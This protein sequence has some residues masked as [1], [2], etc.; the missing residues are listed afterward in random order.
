MEAV[1]KEAIA[2]TEQNG[3]IFLDEIDKIAGRERSLGP[4]VSREG[5]QRDLLPIVEGSTVTTKYGPVK[6]DHILFIA[7]GAFHVAKPSDLIPELQGRF[8]IRVELSPLTKEDFIRILT[9][10]QNALIKQYTA[11]LETEGITLDFTRDALEEIAA[12]AVLVNERSENIGARRLFTI[13]ER[14]LEE[15][16]F[17]A[18]TLAEKK[19]RIDAEAVKNRLK[20]IIKDED[21]SRFIL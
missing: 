7:A 15:I 13:M 19:I 6:T 1:V 4:D 9:E 11:L 20:D 5:V 18:P 16:S 14:L 8:P 21:L 12:S 2:K 10:P 17:E 3:I